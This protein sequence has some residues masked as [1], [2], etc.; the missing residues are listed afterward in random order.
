MATTDEYV[1]K[2][3]K[4][5]NEFLVA[6]RKVA[7]YIGPMKGLEMQAE[8]IE[9]VNKNLETQVEKMKKVIE[10]IKDDRQKLMYQRK[11]EEFDRLKAANDHK[12]TDIRT[13]IAVWAA[14]AESSKRKMKMA[15]TD[16]TAYAEKIELSLD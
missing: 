14:P 1:R 10:K 15:L 6:Y 2:L 11:I 4:A 9:K 7:Q 12:L 8:A 5:I 13:R 16:I 3:G